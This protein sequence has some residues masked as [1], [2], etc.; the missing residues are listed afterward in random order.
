MGFMGLALT[1]EA[2]IPRPAQRWERRVEPFREEPATT[3]SQADAA[4]SEDSALAAA[5]QRGEMRAYER[6]YALQG[7][8]MK[9]LARNILGSSLDAEDAVQE[10]FLKIQRSIS[11]FR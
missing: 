8:R 5:C 4:R 3:V 6:L 2:T 7:G 11:G 9:N 10:T 1:W